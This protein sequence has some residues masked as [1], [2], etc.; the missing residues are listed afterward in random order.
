M[1]LVFLGPP[2]VGKGTQAA[3]L[4]D[5]LKLPHISTGAI[6]RDHLKRETELGKKAKSYMDAGNLVPDELTVSMV[7][8]RLG[9]PDCDAGYILDGFPRNLKQ[10][11]ELDKALQARGES[12]T[13]ALNF[14]AP[15]SVLVDRIA[16]RAEK[17]GRKDDTPETVKNRLEVYDA[18]TGPL[19]PW[20]DG[21]RILHSFD[22]QGTVDEIYARVKVVVE[23][24]KAGD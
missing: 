5:D 1:I 23:G 16:G 4:A 6:F 13:A 2:G 11:E 20:A 18:E 8:D 21:K 14:D 7:M 19:T 17:E 3:K 22:A 24:L 15:R 12:I 9:Q 10:G